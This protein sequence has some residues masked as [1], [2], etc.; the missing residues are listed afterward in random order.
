[1][2]NQQVNSEITRLQLQYDFE[3]AEQSRMLEHQQ[4]QRQYITTIVVLAVSLIIAVLIVMIIRNRARQSEL[5][6]KNLTQD[7]DI[8]K[9]GTYNQCDVPHTEK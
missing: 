6:R 7:V 2:Q 5:K 4:S 9:Q 8:K 1:M 3:K